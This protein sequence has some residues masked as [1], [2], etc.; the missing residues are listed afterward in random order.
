MQCMSWSRWCTAVL[1]VFGPRSLVPARRTAAVVG[2]A[3]ALV[4][5]A[6]TV[7]SPD[8]VTLWEVGTPVLFLLMVTPLL[9]AGPVVAGLMCLVVPLVGVLTV[10]ALDL[11]TSDATTAGQI[12]FCVPALY[13]A[14]HLRTGGVVLVAA[15]ALAGEAVVVLTLLPLAT[16]LTDLAYVGTSMGIMTVLL[17]RAEGSR[18]RLVA[19]LREQAARDVL[20]GLATRRALDDAVRRAL[21][22]AG[23]GSG[24]GLVMVDV[25]HFKAVND[26]YG[27][28]V[29]DD[30]LRHIAA[31]LEACSRPGDVVARMGG[32]E[33]AVLV[34]DCTEQTAVRR[35]REVVDA[36][37]AAPLRTE[38]GTLL[39]LSVS[40]GAGH[41]AADLTSTRVLYAAADDALY[42]VKRAGRSRSVQLPEPTGDPAGAAQTA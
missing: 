23:G 24:T 41:A 26:T 35:A 20:T 10:T 1:S 37:R 17:A 7:F 13:A 14:S 12:F 6:F 34:P 8:P 16:A 29:G 25:D 36:V 32:D 38:D 33:L 5:T 30:A 28:L 39:A 11:V 4:S 40:A 42:A 9:L 22:G 19:A 21:A 15:C 31:V 3:G 2:N 18:E 27:H